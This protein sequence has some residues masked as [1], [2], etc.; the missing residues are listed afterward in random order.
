LGDITAPRREIVWHML[1]EEFRITVGYISAVI[2]YI[3]LKVN[4]IEN[5]PINAKIVMKNGISLLNY[6]C[7][8]LIYLN[9]SFKNKITWWNKL[10]KQ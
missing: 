9:D 1:S 5:L 6:L 7:F 8:F 4:E 3:Q 10:S 2:T